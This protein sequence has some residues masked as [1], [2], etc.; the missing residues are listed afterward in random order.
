MAG[1]VDYDSYLIYNPTGKIKQLDYIK[2]TTELGNTSIALC[3]KNVGIIIAHVPRRSKL[4]EHQNKIFKINDNSLFT[5]SGIT[6]DGLQMVDYLKTASLVEDVIKD[7]PI[8]YLDVFEDLCMDA[9]ERTMSEGSRMYGA[10]GILMMDYDGIKI[11]EFEPTGIAREVIG[12][13]MGNRSQSCRTILEN[14][15]AQFKNASLDEL[16]SIGMKALTNAHPD[17]EENSLKLEDVQIYA[18]EA[19][20]GIAKIDPENLTRMN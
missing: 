9:A 11:V 14:E 13:S 20:K 1:V 17:P 10:S 15:H 12:V 2:R 3:N 8:H 6:N 7:R 4:A 16:L 19:G 5:F 18:I